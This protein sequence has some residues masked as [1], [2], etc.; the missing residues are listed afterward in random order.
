MDGAEVGGDG[1]VYLY[2]CIVLPLLVNAEE[3]YTNSLLLLII[4]CWNGFYHFIKTC[5]V[6]NLYTWI[7]S[8]FV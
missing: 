1:R 5:S 8:L 7:I 2:A 4:V 6:Y 3:K